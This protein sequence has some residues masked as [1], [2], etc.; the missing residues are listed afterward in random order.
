MS[1]DAGF[2]RLEDAEELAEGLALLVGQLLGRGEEV[3]LAGLDAGRGI[4]EGLALPD[5][6]LAGDPDG[7]L[8]GSRVPAPG[9]GRES[10]ARGDALSLS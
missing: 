3:A 5:G 9:G 6:S 2:R 1:P 7:L 4:R 8:M 10:E